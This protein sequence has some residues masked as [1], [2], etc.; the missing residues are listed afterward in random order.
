ME[1]K[2][3]MI[4]DL[5]K[6]NGTSWSEDLKDKYCKVAYLAKGYVSSV[7]ID[8]SQKEPY[9]ES[10]SFEPILLTPAIL[11]KNGF[12]KIQQLHVMKSHNK[13]YPHIFFIEYNTGNKSLFINDGLLP[14]PVRFVHELQHILRLCAVETEITL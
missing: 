4:G 10:R 7:S 3:L 13:I 1:A 14:K 5:I 12:E 11:E 2:D 9:G 8:G 6:T